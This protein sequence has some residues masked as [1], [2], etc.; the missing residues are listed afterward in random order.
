MNSDCAFFIGRDHKIC[1]DYAIS[2]NVKDT[3]YVIIADGCSSSQDTDIGARFL[4]KAGESF[5]YQI[6]VGP[7]PLSSLERFHQQTAHFA[8]LGTK[9][10]KLDQSCLDATMLTI[11]ANENGFV[12]TCYGDGVVALVRKDGK[13]ELISVDFVEGYPLY[14]SYTLDA[15]RMKRFENQKTNFKEVTR[16]KIP[17]IDHRVGVEHSKQT[18]EFHF[19]TSDEYLFAA[20]LSDGVHTFSEMAEDDPERVVRHVSMPEIVSLILA[21]KS[22]SGDFVHRRMQA[23]YKICA[24]RRWQ[25]HDDLSVGVVYL[26]R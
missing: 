14:I 21:F 4:A 20:V 17:D 24:A 15:L 23:F 11:K 13:L 5:I 6:Q 12:A 7:E 2:Q 18:I 3:S 25:H 22:T 1:Q 9:V 10:L 16:L 26:G 19:G 8:S